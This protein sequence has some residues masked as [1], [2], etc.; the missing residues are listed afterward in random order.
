VP[1]SSVQ[2]GN[3]YNLVRKRNAVLDL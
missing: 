3:A 1:E 2:M